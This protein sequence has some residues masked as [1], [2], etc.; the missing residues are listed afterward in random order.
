MEES[1]TFQKFIRNFFGIDR[2][3][4]QLQLLQELN[5]AKFAEIL[6]AIETN[7]SLI[8]QSLD[9]LVTESQEIKKA[10]EDAINSVA[11]PE[12]LEAALATLT[13]NNEKLTVIKD[14]VTQLIPTVVSPDEP[15]NPE[16]PAPTPEPEPV[17]ETPTDVVVEP[18]PDTIGLPGSFEIDV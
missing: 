17:P 16:N 4:R 7:G 13:T 10:L 15:S 2:L 9:S 6:T 18:S 12:Q 8:N 14:T 5:M 11:T 3:E 1:I